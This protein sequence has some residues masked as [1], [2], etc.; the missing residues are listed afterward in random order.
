MASVSLMCDAG[1]PK[2]SVT[3]W[4]DGVGTEGGSGWEGHMSAYG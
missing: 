4:K 2:C 1:D 3:T